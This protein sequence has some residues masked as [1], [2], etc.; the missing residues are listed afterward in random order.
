MKGKIKNKRKKERNR[1]I[2][3]YYAFPNAKV[4]WDSCYDQD[5]GSFVRG[6][7]VVTNNAQTMPKATLQ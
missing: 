3:V 7:G 6:D 1:R 5:Y 2:W 4:I